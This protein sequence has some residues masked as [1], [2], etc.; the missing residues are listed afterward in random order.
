M[1]PT[2]YQRLTQNEK[3]CTLLTD[4][5][6]QQARLQGL[7]LFCPTIENPRL[8]PENSQNFGGSRVGLS[9]EEGLTGQYYH[10]HPSAVF[11]AKIM[12]YIATEAYTSPTADCTST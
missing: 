1:S 6:D 10:N 8:V 3:L 7:N 9:R 5:T 11:L 2:G 4:G 12:K